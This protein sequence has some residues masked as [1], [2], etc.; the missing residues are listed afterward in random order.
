MLSCGIIQRRAIIN[1]PMMCPK[2]AIRLKLIIEKYGLGSFWKPYNKVRLKRAPNKLRKN[3]GDKNEPTIMLETK[4][5]TIETHAAVEKSKR[6]REYK[7]IIL[8]IPGLMPGIGLGRKNSIT[9]KIIAIAANFATVWS[10]L[11]GLI[12]NC[13]ITFAISNYGDSNLIWKADNCLVNFIDPTMMYAVLFGTRRFYKA[14]L[15][16]INTDN[17]RA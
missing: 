13:V 16:F 5:L 15:T 9:D 14:G 3:V 6:T 1:C 4:T 17:T 8:A 12:I 2:D 10:F 7:I 11:V